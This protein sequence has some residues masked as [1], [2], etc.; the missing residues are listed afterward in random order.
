MSS[1][2]FD[3]AVVG[4]GIVGLAHALAATRAGKRV[5]VIDRDA[6]ANSASI[7]NFGFV[8]VTGQQVGTVWNRA[9]RSRD[10]WAEVAPRA[11]IPVIHRG[12][13]VIAHRPEAAAV[14]EAFVAHPEMGPGCE[15]LTPARMAERLPLLRHE[16]AAA[17][18]WSPHEMRVEPRHAIPLLAA[19]L[20][21]EK[22]VTFL[23]NTLVKEIELPRVKTTSGTVEAGQAVVCPGGDLLSLYP[24]VWAKRGLD[25]CKLHMLRLA[26]QGAGWVL[27]GSIM[28]DMSLGRYLGFSELPAAAD[29]KAVL[30]AEEGP[31]L[32]NGIHLIV[33]QS[34]DGSL[35][36]GDSHHYAATPDPFAPDAVDELMIGHARR[37]LRL[38]S[39][40]VVERWLGVYPHS[41]TA[42]ALIE[43]AAPG[44]R[45]VM[46]T[47]GTGMSTGFALAEDALAG[48][49]Q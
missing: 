19:W 32:E 22:G 12:T 8:T 16:D 30:A 47:S 13:A 35:V 49:L 29:L 45:A 44:V 39:D 2:P 6:Q 21:R 1:G 11:G 38:H 18:L 14:V 46:V 23:R 48:W 28:N 37:A 43:D 41:A 3:L 9:R 5:V 26:P 31:S 7:R 27:P 40:R 10:I 42:A 34:A 17:C 20:E 24:E 33:V 36:V 15:M 4:A 25:L